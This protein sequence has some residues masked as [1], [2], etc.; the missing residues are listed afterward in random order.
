[1]AEQRCIQGSCSI[2]MWA[3]VRVY[4]GQLGRHV[5]RSDGEVVTA[6]HRRSGSL[7]WDRKF[8]PAALSQSYRCCGGKDA[9]GER[10]KEVSPNG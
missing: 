4:Y 3:S 10:Q 9:D 5:I 7:N 2:E 1:M 8:P 6:G